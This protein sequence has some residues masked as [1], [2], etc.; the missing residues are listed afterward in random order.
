MTRPQS[1]SSCYF[2]TVAS[3]QADPFIYENRSFMGIFDTHPVNPGHALVIPKRHVASLFDLRETEQADYFDA[4]RGVKGVIESTDLNALY[5]EMRGRDYLQDRPLDHIDTV[6]ELPFLGH[7]PD[8]YTIGNNDGRE[9][10]RSIDHLHVI[11]L[12]R[13]SGDI[14]NP[15][16][17]IRNVIPSRAN[18]Q[19]R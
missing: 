13:Y 9:A 6:L 3:G 7:K 18:Y 10:G 2:C 16:G 1:E 8:A 11:L 12:P 14:E 5:Q 17:G 4:I 15:R 19:R